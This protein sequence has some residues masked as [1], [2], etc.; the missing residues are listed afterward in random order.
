MNRFTH[1]L[2]TIWQQAGLPKFLFFFIAVWTAVVI[3]GGLPFGDLSGYDDAAYAHEA[4]VMAQS[5]DWWT[6]SLNGNPDFDKPPL[7]I[8]LVALAFKF[9]GATDLVAKFPGHWLVGAR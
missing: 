7:Y 1:K 8:W 9:F 4:K 2:K 5:G 6:M 3:L